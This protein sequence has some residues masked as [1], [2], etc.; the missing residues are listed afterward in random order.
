MDVTIVIPVYNEEENVT[1]L[2][3]KITNVMKKRT[4]E[5]EILIVDDGSTDKSY[6][7]LLEMKKDVEQL[8]LIKFKTN[9]GQT[10]ALAAGFRYARGEIII[11]M[12]ADLQNDPEDIPALLEKM[13]E[14][15]DVV[16]GWRKDRK[17]PFINRRLPSIMANWLISRIT[18][19]YLHDYG[20]T[21]KA[22]RKCILDNFQLYGELHRFIPA[23]T[24]WSGARITEIPVNHHPR[25]YGTS[26]Y[27]IGRTFKVILDLITVKFLM[28]FSTQPL[29]IFGGV[30]L[31]S[32][33]LGMLSFLIVIILKLSMNFNMT[34]N[35]LLYLSILF[36]FTA[37][38]FI[39]MGLLAEISIRTYHETLDKPIYVIEMINDEDV[40]D[41]QCPTM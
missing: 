14:K 27:G 9:F 6:E 16:S 28:S 24:S 41:K 21:L 11:T 35:P 18:K 36:I 39:M 17:D 12:D 8:R 26:K 15:Y 22:Y 32:F 34:G 23:L 20:C 29:H 7:L 33:L 30:G 5:W 25:L 2:I 31:V 3:P 37:T 1:R 40:M 13:A 4:E 19:V 10:A 38:Q